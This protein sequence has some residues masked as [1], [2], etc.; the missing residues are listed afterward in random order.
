MNRSKVFVAD[1]S[2]RFKGAEKLLDEF[3]L[4]TEGTVALKANYNSD[5][6]FPATTHPDTLRALIEG[7]KKM[8]SGEIVM[9]ERSGMGRTRTILKNRG[10]LDLSKKLGFKLA[11]LDAIALEGWKDISDEGL[12]WRNGFMI[13]RLFLE[14]DKVVQ[15]CCFKTHRFGGHFT[16]SLKNSVGL[17]AA[18]PPGIKY[19]YMREL[20]TS[21]FQRL[22]IA[23]IN[24]FYKTDL[25]LMDAAQGFVRGGP[26]SGELVEP[27]VL[28]AS[29]D[30][31]AIDAVGVA[32]LRHYGTTPEVMSGRIFDLEQI[33]R[34]CRL[35]VG[36]TSSD[37]I[38][39][40]PMDDQGQKACDMIKNILD[41]QG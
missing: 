27:K 35:G 38:D 24:K 18:R 1:A 17:V 4:A 14:A 22:M 32:L 10:V 3:D 41:S 39:L 34:A 8:V 36:V 6:T 13:A 2:N 30:R 31:V 16:M 19:D 25:V 12:H 7:I 11:D 33:A 28:L 29:K 21:P 26:E 40:I 20:H 23:E 37:Q 15:T 9:A 5:D